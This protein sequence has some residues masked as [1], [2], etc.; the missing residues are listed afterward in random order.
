MKP[1]TKL[2]REPENETE[3]KTKTIELVR[4]AFGSSDAVAEVVEELLAEPV[5]ESRSGE[6]AS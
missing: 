6:L 3:T 5:D 4:E 2:K 1:K